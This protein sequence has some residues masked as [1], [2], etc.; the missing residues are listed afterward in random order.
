MF[1]SV[2]EVCFIPLGDLL[3]LRFKANCQLIRRADSLC[4][5]LL[6]EAQLSRRL[7]LGPE[8]AMGLTTIWD[9][10]SLLPASPQPARGAP[11]DLTSSSTTSL[12]AA[13]I[14]LPEMMTNP[15][16][17]LNKNGRTALSPPSAGSA[18]QQG[19]AVP[20]RRHPK[21]ASNPTKNYEM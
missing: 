17:L 1:L 15:R 6:R 5:L 20:D 4:E 16:R 3:S 12:S 8:A 19:S 11:T 10:A 14:H 13:K 7:T 21:P 18:S 2:S 9:T